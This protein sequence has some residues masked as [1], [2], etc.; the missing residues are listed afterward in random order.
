MLTGK[1]KPADEHT[2]DAKDRPK[3]PREMEV[4][5]HIAK[6]YTNAEIA[7]KLFNSK[8]TIETHRQNLLQKT[9]CKNTATHITY[10]FRK[11]LI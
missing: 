3:S 5:Q 7:D 8:R 4:L 2:K 11:G 10:A 9:K 1:S 6:G